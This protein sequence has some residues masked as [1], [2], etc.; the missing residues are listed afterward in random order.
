MSVAD[1]PDAPVPAPSGQRTKW[2]LIASL[3]LNLLIAGAVAGAMFMHRG[4]P[5]G[6]WGIGP[7]DF[8]LMGFA[9]SLPPERRDMVREELK[10]LRGALKPMRQEIRAAREEAANLLAADPFDRNALKAA[11]VKVGT[12]E[13][14]MRGTSVDRLLGVIDRFTPAERQS[15]SAAWKKKMERGPKRD[16]GA[17][18]KGD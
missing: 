2:L 14:S 8:G 6:R 9:R 12:A 1:T 11:L 13:Q 15:L 16:K 18:D 4:G 7:Q 5:H 3:G 17:D 10:G